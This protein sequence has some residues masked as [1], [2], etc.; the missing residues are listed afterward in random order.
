MLPH[1]H[2]ALLG[3]ASVQMAV[4]VLTRTLGVVQHSVVQMG[5]VIVETMDA[6]M[7]G[8]Y[9]CCNCLILFC[10]LSYGKVLNFSV[11]KLTNLDFI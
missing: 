4:A 8:E 7:P 5:I 9:Q 2:L 1:Q 6:A 10:L 11:K 3:M